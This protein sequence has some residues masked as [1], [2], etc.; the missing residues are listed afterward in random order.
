MDSRAGDF[1]DEDEDVIS[2]GSDAS[3][4]M[5][6]QADIEENEPTLI[7]KYNE[8]KG[9]D[10]ELDRLEDSQLPSDMDDDKVYE[11]SKTQHLQQQ[12]ATEKRHI[13]AVRTL[14]LMEIREENH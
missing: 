11:L 10:G 3:R 4:L 7:E 13:K 9:A 2:M 6:L 1:E 12:E 8:Q 5:R 14:E